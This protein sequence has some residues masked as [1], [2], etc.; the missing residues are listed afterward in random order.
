MGKKKIFFILCIAILTFCLTSQV[1]HATADENKV[2]IVDMEIRNKNECRVH[3][4][5]FIDSDGDLYESNVLEMNASRSAYVTYDLDGKFCSFTGKIVTSSNT[6]PEAS[7][8]IAIFVD[9]NLKWDIS[10]FSGYS[11]QE[12]ISLDLEGAKSL[13]IKTSESSNTYQG[14]IFFVNSMFTKSV[15]P[16]SCDEYASLT[17]PFIIDSHACE[18]SEELMQDS[19]GEFH[20]GAY[21]FSAGENAYV[22]LNLGKNYSTLDFSIVASPKTY[23]DAAMSVKVFFDNEEQLDLYCPEITK[24]TPKID[25]T[26]VNVSD[27]NVLEI[28][29]SGPSYWDKWVYIVDDRLSIHTHQKGGWLVDTEPTCSKPGLEVQYCTECGKICASR[30]SKRLIIQIPVNGLKV[31]ILLVQLKEKKLPIALFV[32]MFIKHNLLRACHIPS[33]QNGRYPLKRVVHLLGKK[34]DV[35]L[36]VIL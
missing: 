29:T 27:V 32:E 1:V 8:N 10:N 36:N 2:N 26:S 5:A 15:S 4:G 21:S 16:V 12:E 6:S 22:K 7:I 17:D 24:S 3:L 18:H 28:R 31:C 14:R 13:S 23:S 30:Q 9:E 25:F 35:V 34:Y 20:N 19:F 33:A 11:N